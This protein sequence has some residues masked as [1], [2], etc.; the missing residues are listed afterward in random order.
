MNNLIVDEKNLLS[1]FAKEIIRECADQPKNNVYKTYPTVLKICPQ[2]KYTLEQIGKYLRHIRR[3]IERSLITVPP[4]YPP[5]T[6]P[7]LRTYLPLPP[8]L[9]T[10]NRLLLLRVKRV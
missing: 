7:T 2:S 1:S 10:K 9:Q 4:L 8:H 5:T 6:K 3:G